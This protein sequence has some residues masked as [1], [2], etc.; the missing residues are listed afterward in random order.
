MREKSARA[1]EYP[2]IHR[3]VSTQNKSL[4]RYC[5]MIVGSLY[6]A[7]DYER[8]RICVIP[9][10]GHRQHLY[11][12]TQKDLPFPFSPSFWIESLARS[13]ARSRR[14]RGAF[15]TVG[16]SLS[17]SPVLAPPSPG[18]YARRHQRSIC[19]RSGATPLS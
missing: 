5:M 6:A 1:F 14:G 2:A 4:T 15:S 3:A 13:S 18:V 8:D 7:V 16:D 19:S 10:R 12:D 11:E 17:P 9:C